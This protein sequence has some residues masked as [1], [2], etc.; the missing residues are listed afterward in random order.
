MKLCFLV[1]EKKNFRGTL[2]RGSVL[3]FLPGEYMC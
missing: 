1:R 2:E 3:V